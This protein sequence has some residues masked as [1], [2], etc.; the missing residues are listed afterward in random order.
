[1]A[2]IA[3]NIEYLLLLPQPAMNTINSVAD[4]TAKKNKMPPSMVNGV[5]FRP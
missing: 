4:P 1:M 5:M 3:P 2:R